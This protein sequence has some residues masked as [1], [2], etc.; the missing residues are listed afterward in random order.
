MINLFCIYNKWPTQINQVY[1]YKVTLINM[2]NL[3]Y[4]GG[5]L[6]QIW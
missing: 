1:K 2:V 3:Q 4:D 5:S 6:W